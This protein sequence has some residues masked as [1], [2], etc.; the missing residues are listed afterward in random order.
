MTGAWI[1]AWVTSGFIIGVLYVMIVQ[2]I[3][4]GISERRGHR[5]LLEHE[6]RM[7]RYA[8]ERASHA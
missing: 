4:D 1:A 3:V 2:T 6:A 7:T 5:R 8:A